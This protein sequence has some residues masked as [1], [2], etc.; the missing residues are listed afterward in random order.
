MT[1]PL[2]DLLCRFVDP[3]YWF[4]HEARPA[5]SAFRASNGKLSTFHCDRVARQ[6]SSLEDLCFDYLRGFGEA[7]LAARDF[8][9]AAEKTPSPV[10]QPTVVWR[11]E[12][13]P[14]LWGAWR[15]AHVNI[16]AEAGNAGFP[17]AYRELLAKRC[18]VP[19]RPHGV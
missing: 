5:A 10:F 4:P 15:D 11:P 19:R 16:E 6:G 9:E 13:A 18:E 3:E 17:P 2:D 1:V 7:I 12:E 14:E 8:L